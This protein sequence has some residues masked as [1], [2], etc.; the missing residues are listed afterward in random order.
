ME[1]LT[2]QAR[3]RSSRNELWK[4]DEYSTFKYFLSTWE[5]YS[6]QGICTFHVQVYTAS[7][8]EKKIWL[9][10]KVDLLIYCKHFALLWSC[11]CR[12]TNPVQKYKLHAQMS[13]TVHINLAGLSPVRWS[14]GC[15]PVIS[16]FTLN[17]I[18]RPLGRIVTNTMASW[19]DTTF[20]CRSF[21]S[22]GDF[23]DF[24]PPCPHEFLNIGPGVWK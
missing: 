4:D 1:R 8:R 3:L 7:A 22:F 16:L 12:K 10:L 21:S 24:V 9:G 5:Y 15:W 19:S 17:C 14:L 18:I 2:L 20:V 6:H 23:R 11:T 13:L